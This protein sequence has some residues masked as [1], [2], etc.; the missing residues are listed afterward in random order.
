MCGYSLKIKSFS[1]ERVRKEAPVSRGTT[2]CTSSRRS[3][4]MSSLIAAFI[5]EEQRHARDSTFLRASKHLQ[6]QLL[7]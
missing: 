5:R 3:R 7:G 1:W 2:V 4:I 6:L